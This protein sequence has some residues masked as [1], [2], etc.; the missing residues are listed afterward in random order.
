MNKSDLLTLI[1]DYFRKYPLDSHAIKTIS[2]LEE[3]ELFW[4]K[5]NLLGHIT[6]S[7]WVINKNFNLTLLTHHLKLNKWLQLGGHIEQNDNKIFDSCIREV[8]EESGL[9]AIYF[10]SKEIFDIDVHI[11]PN[12]K[13]P[14]LSHLHYDIRFLIIASEKEEIKFDFNESNCVKWFTFNEI[15]NLSVDNSL[16]RMIEK[17]KK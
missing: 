6:A 1:Y 16:Y 10:Y 5:E 7:A 11:I 4:Q 15:R 14:L 13:N 3:N 17:T 8:K 2:F 9:E 12:L